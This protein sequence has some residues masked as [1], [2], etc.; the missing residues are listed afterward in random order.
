MRTPARVRAV[1]RPVT[2][3]KM[4][5]TRSLRCS[6]RTSAPAAPKASV[7]PPAGVTPTGAVAGGAATG[8]GATPELAG[9]ALAPDPGNWEGMLVAPKAAGAPTTRVA[10]AARPARRRIERRGPVALLGRSMILWSFPPVIRFLGCLSPA[11]GHAPALRCCSRACPSEVMAA[12]DPSGGAS[13][14][15]PCRGIDFPLL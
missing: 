10:A 5:R 6:V 1:Y 3:T 14:V 13:R 15:N 4:C 12:D 8:C 9:G 7:P 11:V 2:G